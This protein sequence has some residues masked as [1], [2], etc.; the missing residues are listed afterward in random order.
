MGRYSAGGRALMSSLCLMMLVGVDGERNTLGLYG[1]V[2]IESY[3][4]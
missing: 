3:R 2:S 1:T 4:S